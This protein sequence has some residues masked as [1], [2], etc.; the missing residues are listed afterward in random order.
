MVVLT[1]GSEIILQ[2]YLTGIFAVIAYIIGHWIA[3]PGFLV[4]CLHLSPEEL[5]SF[6]SPHMKNWYTSVEFLW[7]SLGC[8]L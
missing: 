4:A 7:H 3:N 5:K 8:G 2:E 6:H 1:A